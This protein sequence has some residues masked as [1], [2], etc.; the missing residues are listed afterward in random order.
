MTVFNPTSDASQTMPRRVAYIVKR[1]PR[2]SETFVVNEI[3]AHESAGLAIEIFALRPTSDTHFQHAIADVRAAVTHLRYGGVKVESFWEE[4]AACQEEFGDYWQL[5]SKAEGYS[6]IEAYQSL[7]LARAIRTRSIQHVHAHFATSAAAVARLAALLAGVSYSITAHAKDIFHEDIDQQLLGRKLHDASAVVTVSDYN[8]EYLRS[9]FP[10]AA[11][12]ITRIYNGLH[13]DKYEYHKP[14]DRRPLIL[15]VGRLVE[16]KGFDVLIES[17]RR[18]KEAQV[19]FECVIAGGGDLEESLQQQIIQCNL[20][21]QITMLGPRSHSQVVDLMKESAVFVAPCVTSST[22]DRDGLPTVIL[23]AMAVGTPCVSTDLVGIPEVVQHDKTGMLVPERDAH[24][25]ADSIQAL[26]E[27]SDLAQSLSM[28][29]RRLIEDQ[30]DAG[31]NTNQLRML[32]GG[33]C[34]ETRA[35]TLAEVG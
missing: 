8:V 25:L 30:F 23:E 5:L 27:N 3:L 34:S 11:S 1:Y 17:C 29:A 16:K 18:L 24:A 14:I 26:L 6:A 20:Q 21:S 31:K 4:L 13:L 2:F 9:R 35:S 33:S 32:F 12:R 10:A 7:Q 15:A 28:A 19:T 22:G